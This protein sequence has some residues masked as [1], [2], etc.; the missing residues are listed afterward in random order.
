M[1]HEHALNFFL[2]ISLF[3]TIFK[4]CQKAER[5]GMSVWKEVLIMKYGKILRLPNFQKK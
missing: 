5:S 2:E 3:H 1:K 4:I